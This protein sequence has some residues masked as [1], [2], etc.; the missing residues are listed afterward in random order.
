MLDEKQLAAIKI[1]ATILVDNGFGDWHIKL[2]EVK[3]YHAQVRFDQKLLTWNLQ[4]I[5]VATKEEFIGITYHELA[6]ILVGRGNGHNQKFKNKYHELTGNWDYSKH[7]ARL[8]TKAFITEC[9]KC[10]AIGSRDR[11]DRI[12]YCSHCFGVDQS[13]VQVKVMPTKTVEWK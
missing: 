12:R 9:P 5:R 10:G 1:V 3:S 7:S 2:K 11:N 8:A 6:H 4:S 13:K